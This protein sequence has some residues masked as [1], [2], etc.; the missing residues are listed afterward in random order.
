MNTI[1]SSDIVVH[2]GIDVAK[3]SLQVD[4]QGTS[5]SFDNSPKGRAALLSALPRAAFVIMEATGSYHLRLLELLHS[6]GVPA[7]VINPVWVK[8]FAGAAGKLAKTDRS[9]AAMLSAF[10]QTF[11]PAP[12]SPREP[13]RVELKELL[14]IRD[15]L[16]AETVLW[17]NFMEHQQSAVARK[18]TAS[19]LKQATAALAKVEKRISVL[20]EESVAIAPAARVIRACKGIGL[21]TTAVLLAEMPELGQVGR[22]E[23]A[24]L[25]GLAPYSND[26]GKSEGPRHI[27]AG[28]SNVKRALYMASLSAVRHDPVLGPAYKQLRAKG[29]PSKVA[30]V[31]IARRLL[32]I[33]NARLRDLYVEHSKEKGDTARYP[34]K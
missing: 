28:R 3:A 14:A 27:R 8:K 25:A 2:I 10:G 31:A 30:L 22:R 6:R 29:K 16:V 24:A 7:A 26:S 15:T 18:M 20:L 23:I 11:R 4:L 34:T 1:P 13:E 9:D 21:V 19:R 33:I 32:V 12:T 5:T 17:K